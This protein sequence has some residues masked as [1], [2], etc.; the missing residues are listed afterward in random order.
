MSIKEIVFKRRKDKPMRTIDDLRFLIREPDE[1]YHA[2]SRDYLGS[3]DLIEFMKNPLLFH[4]KR[5]GLVT[6]RESSAFNLGRAAH[7]LILEGRDRFE[8]EY[9]VGGP[10]NSSTGQ[11]YGANTK[12]YARWAEKQDKAVLTDSDAALVQEMN[13]AVGRH[14]AANELLAE[15]IPEGVGRCEY[16]G[17]PC[18]ARLDWLNPEWGLIDLKTCHNLDVFEMD[19]QAYRYAHQMAFYT[20]LLLEASG[21]RFDVHIVA[22]EKQEPFRCGVWH[23]G[24]D[25]LKH[26]RQQNEEAMRRLRECQE[27]DVWPTGYE[28]VREFR[29]Y[30]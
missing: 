25:I 8:T 16:Q 12:A 4:K 26:A 30:L 18:Q 19:A 27:Q 23:V 5:V 20:A 29:P 1:V 28:G 24:P 15:G 10:V 3:H 9:A 17:L 13:V 2:R 11:P 22:V 14:E 21:R 6:E 7:V